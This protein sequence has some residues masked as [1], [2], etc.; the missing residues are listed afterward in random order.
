MT[1]LVLSD[2]TVGQNTRSR[3][4]VN[5]DIPFSNEKNVSFLGGRRVMCIN[6]RILHGGKTSEVLHIE[7]FNV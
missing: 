1:M 3:L 2:R 5:T 4:V 7:A 6:S